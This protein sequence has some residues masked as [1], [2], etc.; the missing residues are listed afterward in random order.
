MIFKSS[1]VAFAGLFFLGSILTAQHNTNEILSSHP[2]NFFRYFHMCFPRADQEH[3]PPPTTLDPASIYILYDVNPPEGF[4]LRRDVYIRLAVFLRSLKLRPGHSNAKLVLPPWSELYHWR[5][6]ILNQ[7]HIPWGHFFDLESMKRYADV[8]ELH[9]LF[10][11]HKLR[12]PEKPSIRID[13][14]YQL[15][16][17]EDMFENGVFVDKFERKACT[18]G[19]L[20]PVGGVHGVMGYRNIT[21]DDRICVKFQ[22]S[23]SLLFNMFEKFKSSTA[24]QFRIIFINNAE[25]VLHDYWGNVDYWEAR[26]SLR[27]N[28][29][30]V[31][32]AN[33][34][35]LE[36]FNSTNEWDRVQRPA[37]WT[38]EKPYRRARGGEYLCA[39]IRRAD[40]MY[41]RE[42]TTPTLYSAAIQIKRKLLE[43]GLRKIFISSD[44]SKMDFHELKNYL[45][46]FKVVRYV[47]ESQQEL[48]RFKDGGV[49]IIDQIICSHAR[50]FIG[51]YESTFTYRIYEE[52][53]IL[54][55]P[56]DLTFN[57]FCREE[58]T[59]N[60]ERNSIWPIQYD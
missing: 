19:P 41:G 17:F 55:F 44:G 37:S 49:A 32:E 47:P 57:T 58:E 3:K 48:A 13:E 14:Y 56:K 9:E 12:F 15:L 26:R 27:F 4:N 39:H 42:R 8:I 43:L 11:E 21:I 16:N 24:G 30:L 2:Y 52:R 28:A 50:F 18:K 23:A 7:L 22:G 20:P 60:C 31:Q 34:F 54:G 36:Q 35:R 5:S 40:F 1:I 33:R 38:D 25:I 10:T 46:R 53:E 45:K 59:T 29:Q 51:T 6:S